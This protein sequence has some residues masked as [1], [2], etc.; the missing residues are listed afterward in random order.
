MFSL[1]A[2]SRT[3]CAVGRMTPSTTVPMVFCAPEASSDQPLD[4]TETG[5]L[6]MSLPPALAEEGSS[7][8]QTDPTM[9]AGP[10]GESAQ[11]LQGELPNPE[12][13]PPWLG[14]RFLT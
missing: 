4:S 9:R 2:G 3:A 13:R 14:G 11:H 6:R 8:Q 1:N 10:A 7:I 5:S 12:Y